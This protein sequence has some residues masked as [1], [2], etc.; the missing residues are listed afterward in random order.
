LLVFLRGAY[1][2]M[3][4]LVPTHSSLYREVRPN[5]AIQQATPLDAHWGLHPAL[6][7][8]LLPLAQTGQ[9]VFVPF[10]GTALSTRSHFETQDRIEWGGAD[11]ASH[12]RTSGFLGRLALRLGA[13]AAQPMAFSERLPL[14]LQG[15]PHAAN[16][17]L[18]GRQRPADAAMQQALEAMYKDSP[19]AGRV[20]RGFA[21]REDV[22]RDQLAN[23]APAMAPQARNAEARQ[24][25][26]RTGEHTA[27]QREMLAAT[28]SA[29]AA[30]RFEA[31]ARRMAR[32]M[33]Q[34]HTLAFADVGGWDTHVNQG[35][36]EGALAARLEELGRGL[37]AYA[38]ELGPA[39][40]ARSTVVV[41]SEFGRTLRE[42]GNRG[43]DHGHG[44]VYWV[45]GGGLA[46]GS[47]G[48]ARPVRGEQLTIE[49]NSLHENRDLPVLNDW[50]G[51][52]AGLWGRQYGLSSA[53]LQF[54]FPQ[55][56]PLDLGLV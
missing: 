45:M 51:L 38:D 39:L 31:D 22:R 5:I 32:L 20:Q 55:V 34:Q 9:A 28:R 26:A 15:H 19:L 16:V 12:A 54:V 47:G 48:A 56:K 53:D 33:K 52:L 29:A 36:D 44:S 27:E 13:R 50:R 23:D 49:A 40:W 14:A 37:A 24:M 21:A 42:N 18:R 8:S 10:A 25:A 41:I 11:H 3:S 2:A 7:S 30:G 46:G 1:D 35:A 43:T 4:A 6:Q 17:S